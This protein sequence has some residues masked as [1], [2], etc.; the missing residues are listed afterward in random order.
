M[1]NAGSHAC[2]E[3]YWT[4][5]SG[6]AGSATQRDQ[7]R[8]HNNRRRRELTSSTFSFGGRQCGGNCEAHACRCYGHP[9]PGPSRRCQSPGAGLRL[10]WLATAM[11]RRFARRPTPAGQRGVQPSLHQGIGCCAVARGPA[12][13]GGAGSR[14]GWQRGPAGGT[15]GQARNDRP[16]PPA[17]SNQGR[18]R[19]PGPGHDRLNSSGLPSPRCP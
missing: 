13:R 6:S 12:V 9:P 17:G 16:V 19:L 1:G 7:T 11:P 8:R 14:A 15:N 2:S 3:G 4:R 18:E 10:H 5:M